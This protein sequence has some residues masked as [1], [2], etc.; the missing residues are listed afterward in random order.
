MLLHFMIDLGGGWVTYMAMSRGAGPT[1]VKV[2]NGV[3]A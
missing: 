2:P 3:A 1:P